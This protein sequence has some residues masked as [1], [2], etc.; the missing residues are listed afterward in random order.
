[1]TFVILDLVNVNFYNLQQMFPECNLIFW[2]INE[3][4]F[5]T[6]WEK[7]FFNVYGCGGFW[8]FMLE[9]FLISNHSRLSRI[10]LS[11]L[12]EVYETLS[13]MRNFSGPLKKKTFKMSLLLMR[14]LWNS[15]IYAKICRS[16]RSR[17]SESRLYTK[18]SRNL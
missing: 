1:M 18:T 2:S 4:Q 10:C 3:E 15:L 17:N 14:A 13:F 8:F 7:Q 12:C 6:N 9:I 16:L 5:P 11:H